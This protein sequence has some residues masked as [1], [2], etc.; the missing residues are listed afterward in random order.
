MRSG[1]LIGWVLALAISAAPAAAQTPPAP[2]APAAKRPAPS[3]APTR[4]APAPGSVAQNPSLDAGPTSTTATYGDWV[5][6]CSQSGDTQVCEVAQTIY[7]QGQQAPIAVVAIGRDKKTSPLR[8]VLQLPLNVNVATRVKI[9][10]KEGD[11]PIELNFEN[12]IPTGCFAVV[13]PA[14]E[15]MRRLRAHTEAGRISYKDASQRDIA[16]QFSLRGLSLALD[17]LLKS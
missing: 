11:V 9:A 16:F 13:Q 15:T 3:A 8:M 12:C 1:S 5:V 14:D 4:P 2:Q 17:A 10:L 7:L 6:R